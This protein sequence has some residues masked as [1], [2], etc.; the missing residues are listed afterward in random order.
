MKEAFYCCS[1]AS[2]LLKLT[3][4]ASETHIHAYIRFQNYGFLANIPTH[5]RTKQNNMPP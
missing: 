3:D 1:F 5:A 2:I 4:A